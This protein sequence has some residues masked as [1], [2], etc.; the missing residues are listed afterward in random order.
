MSTALK[1]VLVVTRPPLPTEVTER[2]SRD[3]AVRLAKTP[4]S[5]TSEGLLELADGAAGLLVGP[6]RPTRR[7]ILRQRRLIG[8][9]RRDAVSGL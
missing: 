4:K 1:P 3:F 6:R 5:L 2:V 7:R 9:D 8:K